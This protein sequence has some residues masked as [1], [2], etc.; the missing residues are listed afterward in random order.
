MSLPD[1]YIPDIFPQLRHG[2]LAEI[3]IVD[4]L[5]IEIRHRREP[6]AIRRSSTFPVLNINSMLVRLSPTPLS[7]A[8]RPTTSSL[9][10]IR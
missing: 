6:A 9:R 4:L 8:A 2:L 7:E 1:S 5:L 3:R 10:S